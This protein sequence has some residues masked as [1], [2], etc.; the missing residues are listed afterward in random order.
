MALDEGDGIGDTSDTD[1]EPWDDEVGTLRAGRLV[2]AERGESADTD[3][4]L[5]AQDIGVDGAAASAEEAAMHVVGDRGS[6]DDDSV[7]ARSGL[8]AA[9]HLGARA[10]R[11]RVARLCS[12]P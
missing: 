9:S 7:H 10:L 1:G 6:Y 8:S 11:D 3:D 12:R 4:E 5:W 2:A